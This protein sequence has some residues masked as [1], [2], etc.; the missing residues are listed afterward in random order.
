[1]EQLFIAAGLINEDDMNF[2][3]DNLM[4]D[5]ILDLFSWLPISAKKLIKYVINTHELLDNYFINEFDER[6][7][8]CITESSIRAKGSEKVNKCI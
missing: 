8:T 3:F 2:S 4:R 1:M 6:S 7:S 5:I